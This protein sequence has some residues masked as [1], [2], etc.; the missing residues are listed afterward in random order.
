[1]SLKGIN[2]ADAGKANADRF[3]AYIEER[4][5]NGTL[6]WGADGK[7]IRS[8]MAQDLQC[9]RDVFRTNPVI[10][11][12]LAEVEGASEHRESLGD[13][14]ARAAGERSRREVMANEKAKELQARVAQL[15]EE[16]RY[17]KAQLRAK[18]YADLTLPDVGR[19]PW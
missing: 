11:Q 19:L 6:P 8:V 14:D 16:N 15:E 18:G 13:A 9:N 7:L 5:A 12:K 2:G 10:R 3:L 1:M 17:L 4:R